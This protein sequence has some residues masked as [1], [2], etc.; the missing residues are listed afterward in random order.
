[1]FEI[2]YLTD[3]NGQPK[4]IVIPIEFWRKLFPEE[5]ISLEQLSEKLEDYCLN[6]AMDEASQ[7]PLLDREAALK[8]LEE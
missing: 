7:T 4:A 2:E 5:Q 6:K 8:Y 3:K 1:M